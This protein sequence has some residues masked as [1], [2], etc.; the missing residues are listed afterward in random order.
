VSH[1]VLIG[2]GSG[3]IGTR[4]TEVLLQK[5]H[6]VRHLGRKAKGAGQVKTFGWDIHR[7]TI[8]ERAF[9]GVDIVVNLA[10]AN[11]NDHRWTD[12]YKKE[13]LVSRTGSTQLIVNVLKERSGIQLIAG[14]AIGYY[15]F[16]ND[17][18]WFRETDPPGNDFMAQLTVEWEKVA[19]QLKNVTHIRTGIIVSSHGGAVE[20]MSKP[21]KFYVGSPLGTGKQIVSWIHLEDECGIIMHVIE[22]KLSGIFNAVAPEPA[23]NEEI[24]KEIAKKL[25]RPLLLPNVPAFA[26]GIILGDM[27]EQVLNGAKISSDKIQ[28]RG[29]KFQYR[30]IREAILSI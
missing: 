27:S 9:D 17:A 22:N 28:S 10:G 21:I 1:C 19:D 20:E 7:Q 12:A 23:T 24:T 26:L 25:K 5:G 15:G 16:G 11:I 14:S 29:Y 4:L 30:T 6:E 2:G 18:H 8:D 3:L 13:M